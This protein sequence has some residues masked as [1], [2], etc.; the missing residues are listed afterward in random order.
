MDA[1]VANLDNIGDVQKDARFIA[2]MMKDYKAEKIKNMLKK[3]WLA[4]FHKYCMENLL[5]DVSRQV[6]DDLLKFE[7][8]CMTLQIIYNSLDI[9]GLADARG[10]EVERRNYINSLGYLY[11]D[12]DRELNDCDSFDKLKA[13]VRGYE[14]EHMLN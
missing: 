12:K 3:I 5:G 10:R 6:M 14:Y 11:P 8:D 2:N 7:S 4:D 13:A 1:C 9:S